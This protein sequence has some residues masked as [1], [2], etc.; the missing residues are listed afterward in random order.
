MEKDWEGVMELVSCSVGPNFKAQRR[1]A[2][3]SITQGIVCPSAR[4]S[5]RFFFFF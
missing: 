3:S 4:K 2:H 1:H 5:Q